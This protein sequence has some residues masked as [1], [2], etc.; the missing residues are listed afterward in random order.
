MLG[1]GRWRRVRLQ[2]RVQCRCRT[3]RLL[4]ARMPWMLWGLSRAWSL[5]VS[6]RWWPI[7]GN[8]GTGF[9]TRRSAHSVVSIRIR[10]AWGHVGIVM[11][12]GILLMLHRRL[13]IHLMLVMLRMLLVHRMMLR[14]MMHIVFV[15]SARIRWTGITSRRHVMSGRFIRVH[16]GGIFGSRMRRMRRSG[17]RRSRSL[18]TISPGRTGRRRFRFLATHYWATFRI[19]S[20]LL[21]IGTIL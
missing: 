6:L 19:P 20:T 15:V 16:S 9:A 4:L 10:S 11:V 14:V 2:Q 13:A 17:G 8:H 3:L 21:S 5:H 1:M 12:S 7:G 18:A